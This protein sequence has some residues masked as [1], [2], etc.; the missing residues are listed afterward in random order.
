MKSGPRKADAA[1]ENGAVK[2]FA[3]PKVL[4]ADIVLFEGTSILQAHGS[5]VEQDN[6][7]ISDLLDFAIYIDADETDIQ[8]WYIQAA[9][10]ELKNV[11]GMDTTIGPTAEQPYPEAALLAQEIWRNV[12]KF[13]F[14]KT[15]L[16]TRSRADLIIRKGSDHRVEEIP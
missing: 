12:G 2:G 16:P 15:I 9:L 6:P 3:A 11:S 4:N 14:T 10:C 7:L 5:E 13:S 1:F 8:R